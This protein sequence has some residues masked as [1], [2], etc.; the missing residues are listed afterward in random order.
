[1]QTC[2]HHDR[3]NNSSDDLNWHPCKHRPKASV[4][5][6]PGFHYHE[7][8]P[9]N[10]TPA[11]ILTVAIKS[12]LKP[13]MNCPLRQG[14]FN[15]SNFQ[16]LPYVDYLKS[17]LVH[18]YEFDYRNKYRTT[19]SSFPILTAFF[20]YRYKNEL[21]IIWSKN[22]DNVPKVQIQISPITHLQCDIL[23]ALSVRHF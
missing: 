1:M 10:G 6:K 20:R 9:S 23:T 2:L 4:L 14:D 21:A 8:R 13:I 15:S 11:L 3:N 16:I 22:I 18:V 12:T 17:S 19:Y 7:Y 5:R